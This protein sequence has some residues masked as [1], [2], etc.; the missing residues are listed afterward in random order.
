MSLLYQTYFGKFPQPSETAKWVA[1]LA[2]V[3]AATSLEAFVL[4]FVEQATAGLKI[5]TEQDLR[6][7]AVQKLQ[8]QDAPEDIG[9]ASPADIA[10]INE[11]GHGT[12]LPRIDLTNA[13]GYVSTITAGQAIQSHFG[14]DFNTLTRYEIVETTLATLFGRTVSPLEVSAFLEIDVVSDVEKF[15]LIPFAVLKVVA[16]TPEDK[17]YLALLAATSNW[18]NAQWA[19]DANVTGSFSQALSVGK[20]GS[21]FLTEGFKVFDEMVEE[22]VTAEFVNNGG[23]ALTMSA[24]EKVFRELATTWTEELNGVKLSQSGFF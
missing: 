24:A 12:E 2:A 13:D 19:T 6:E 15:D 9:Q 1:R 7:L 11:F 3:D 21:Q 17:G 8:T 18:L 16:Q 20:Y 22:K 23:A 10:K 14:D 5:W 4:E